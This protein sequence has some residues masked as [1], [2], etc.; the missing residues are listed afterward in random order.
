MKQEA[1]SLKLK[2]ALRIS[3]ELVELRQARPLELLAQL[4]AESHEALHGLGV[5]SRGQ[6]LLQPVHQRD[7]H[8]SVL[9]RLLVDQGLEREPMFFHRLDRRQDLRFELAQ[10]VFGGIGG[11]CRERGEPSAEPAGRLTGS[12]PQAPKTSRTPLASRRG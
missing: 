9:L 6:G 10:S 4:E 5:L 3:H 7:K 12:F 1:G 11:G 8:L 2:R